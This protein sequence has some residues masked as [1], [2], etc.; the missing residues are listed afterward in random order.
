[1]IGARFQ[2][3][4]RALA[5]LEPLSTFAVASIAFAL[6]PAGMTGHGNPLE[7]RNRKPDNEF[8]DSFGF[9]CTIYKPWSVLQHWPGLFASWSIISYIRV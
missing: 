6:Y 8:A 3:G 9:G 4:S 2:E 1:V 5:A 7:I